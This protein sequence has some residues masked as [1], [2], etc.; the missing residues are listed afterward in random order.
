MQKKIS[1]HLFEWL[2][3]SW[4]GYAHRPDLC[5]SSLKHC[6]YTELHKELIVSL[7]QTKIISKT[8]PVAED[9]VTHD[10]DDQGHALDTEKTAA[11]LDY[12]LHYQ[13][14]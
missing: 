13:S 4:A 9:Y 12:Y 6:D 10:I 5:F 1:P 7:S 2:L 3:A 8:P 14:G 11:E